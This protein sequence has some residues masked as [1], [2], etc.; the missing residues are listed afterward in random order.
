MKF[1]FFFL[2][3]FILVV[4]SVS[5]GINITVQSE[6]NKTLSIINLETNQNVG[7]GFNNQ[8]FVELPYENYEL[9]I[10][11]DTTV[12]TASTITFFE[13]TYNKMVYFAL[14]ILIV[15]IIYYLIRGL[16]K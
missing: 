6:N 3:I 4:N 11:A 14:M 10:L 2:L 15:C 13:G 8:T 16:V 7:T 5:A 9:R 12:S 1:P